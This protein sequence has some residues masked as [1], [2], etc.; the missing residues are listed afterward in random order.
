VEAKK[1]LF[2]IVKGIKA[3]AFLV[4]NHP[5]EGQKLSLFIMLVLSEKLM[6]FLSLLLLLFTM[7]NRK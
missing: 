6:R 3:I 2:K 4:E 1:T 5:S 7:L